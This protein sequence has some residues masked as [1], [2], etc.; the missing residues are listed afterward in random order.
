MSAP[1]TTEDLGPGRARRRPVTYLVFALIT[2]VLVGAG[3][4]V[5]TSR[6]EADPA[7]IDP[8][9]I[10]I[11]LIPTERL[12]AILADSRNDPE[13]AKEI[14]GVMLVLAERHFA[15]SEYGR[16]FDLYTE[17]LAHPETR[18]A[19]YAQSLS[20]VAW[21]GWLSTG[22][23]ASALATV[24]QSLRLSPNNSETLYI[25]AQILWCAEVD[26]SEAITL[27][28]TVLRAE[29]LPPEVRTQVEGDL[30][31]AAAGQSCR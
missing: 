1:Q 26:T 24:D 14:P 17:I 27:L 21:I 3:Y 28:Q 5:Q 18:R 25:K 4:A 9:Q 6:G 22:D 23:A 19:Q 30:A 7:P 8:S 29:D 20:R 13:F 2:V 10:D 12:E 11:G 16:A 31:A 15:D